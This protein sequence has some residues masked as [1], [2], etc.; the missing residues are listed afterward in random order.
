[1]A[2]VKIVTGSNNEIPSSLIKEYDITVIPFSIS[3]GEEH[4][5]DNVDITSKEFLEK[6]KATKRFPKTAALSVGELANT[7]KELSGKGNSIV[8]IHMSSDLSIATHHAAK[9]AK[10][11]AK[12]DVE[13]VDTKQTAGGVGLIVLE[14]AKAAKQGKSREDVVKI[15]EETRSKTNLILALPDMEYLYRGGRIGKAKSLMGSLLKIIPLVAV[16][17][18]EGIVTPLGKARTA[19]QANEKIVET[20]RVDMGKTGA[21][22]IECIISH[23]DNE[24]AANELKELLQK[25]FRCG[26][27]IKK[28]SG[29]AAIVHIGPKAWGVAYYLRK[30]EY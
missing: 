26:Q 10:E 7:Y 23:A 1:M 15:A 12:A 14:A 5:R 13:I 11:I 28:E 25:N 8:S 27:I 18:E 3:L 9:N 2:K 30:E 4:Y 17:N 16:R 19:A 29:C 6:I 21:E 20:I 22:K 24:A